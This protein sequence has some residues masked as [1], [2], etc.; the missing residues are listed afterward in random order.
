MARLS[1]GVA[2]IHVG[3][4]TE[5]EVKEKQHRVEDSPSAT[6]AAIEDCLVNSGLPGELRQGLVNYG[7]ADR[8]PVVGDRRSAG[9]R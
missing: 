6:R 4:A 8:D 5:V 7:R 1:A 9:G 2:V 3:A